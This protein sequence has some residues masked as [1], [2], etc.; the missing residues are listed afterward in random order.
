MLLPVGLLKSIPFVLE[1]A[2]LKMI[3]Y[4]V[5][6]V[7]CLLSYKVWKISLDLSTNCTCPHL[8]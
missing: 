7:I 1:G 4:F 5:V 8:M 3:E 2:V 6:V